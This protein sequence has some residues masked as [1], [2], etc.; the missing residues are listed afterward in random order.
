MVISQLAGGLGNQLFQY[1]YGFS[2]AKSLGVQFKIDISFFEDY[3]WHEYS[4]PPFKI[5][6]DIASKAEIEK[7]KSIDYT[8]VHKFQR[9]VFG[10]KNHVVKEENLKFNSNYLDLNKI[11]YLTGYW[12]SAKYFEE[13]WTSLSSEFDFLYPPSEENLKLINIL[14]K[15]YFSISLHVRRGN[16]ANIESVNKTHGTLSLEYYEKAI[17]YFRDLYENPTFYIFSDDIEWARLNLNIPCNTIYV[18][19]NDDKSDYEDLRIMS[20]CKHNILANSTFS[21]WGAYLNKNQNKVVI[22][23]KSWFNDLEL[24]KQTLDLIPPSWIRI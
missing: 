2:R 4:L 8:L 3:E 6:A 11:S 13:N 23:P 22:A 7:I 5:S 24:N 9:K 20:L 15:D 21:W 10:K 18:D 1:A 17:S 14:D 19:I 16:Y 12:Q